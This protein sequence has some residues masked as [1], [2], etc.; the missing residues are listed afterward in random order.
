VKTTKLLKALK[1]ADR[2]V[3]TKY[4]NHAWI[5]TGH[6]ML[7]VIIYDAG[8]LAGKLN[9]EFGA[10]V[11]DAPIGR[12]VVYNVAKAGHEVADHDM[13][14]LVRPTTPGEPVT[15]TGLLSPHRGALGAYVELAVAGDTLRSYNRAY[16]DIF[17][18]CER[19][20]TLHGGD[21]LS[22]WNAGNLLAFVMPVN[23]GAG[24]GDRIRIAACAILGTVAV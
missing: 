18:E 13:L 4:D 7:R 23:V 8:T 24:Q 21:P 10:A 11:A 1:A 9:T 3:V 17:D 12:S 14:E 15:L 2:V 20:G 5:G 19:V 16:L 6:F 22:V